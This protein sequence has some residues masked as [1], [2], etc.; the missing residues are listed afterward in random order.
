MIGPGGKTLVQPTAQAQKMIN[1]LRTRPV[2][3]PLQHLMRKILGI[4]GAI[5][6]A[7]GKYDILVPVECLC[8]GPPQQLDPW[9]T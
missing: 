1:V 6:E 3:K 5:L 4:M 2:G 7:I 8:A 9:M